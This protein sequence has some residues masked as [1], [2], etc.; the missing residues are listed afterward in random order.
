LNETGINAWNFITK[1]LEDMGCSDEADTKAVEFFCMA[2][3]EY[4]DLMGIIHGVNGE[5][6][7]GRVYETYT[8]GG[9]LRYMLRPEV[10]L[11]EKAWVR[12]KS[13]LPDLCLTTASRIRRSGKNNEK[14]D[15]D[16]LDSFL[17]GIGNKRKG[18]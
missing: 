12:A 10:Q 11:A 6:G 15:D 16:E 5:G 4:H 2:Y 3:E 18:R 1:S 9:E 17:G 13:L 8:N 7:T 14:Q